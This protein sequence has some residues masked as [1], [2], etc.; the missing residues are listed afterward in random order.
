MLKILVIIQNISFMSTISFLNTATSILERVQRYYILN[1]IPYIKDTLI[2]LLYK[3][4]NKWQ[5]NKHP[6][7]NFFGKQVIIHF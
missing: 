1:S 7:I 2:I 6:Y 5:T 4:Q 3:Y